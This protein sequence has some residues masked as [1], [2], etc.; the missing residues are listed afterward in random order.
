MEKWLDILLPLV[1]ILQ[2]LKS[3]SMEAGAKTNPQDLLRQGG[4]RPSVNSSMNLGY[5]WFASKKYAYIIPYYS[6]FHFIFHYPYISL[7]LYPCG[8]T[9]GFCILK[10]RIVMINSHE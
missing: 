4:H 2:S 8:L 6:I 10:V 3:R 1:K 7:I 5:L 9:L